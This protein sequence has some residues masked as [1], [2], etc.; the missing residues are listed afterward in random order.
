MSLPSSR[1]S[2]ANPFP[3]EGYLLSCLLQGHGCIPQVAVASGSAT[4]VWL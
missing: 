3:L 4:V 1:P 2:L